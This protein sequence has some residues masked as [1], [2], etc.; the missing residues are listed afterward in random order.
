MWFLHCMVKICLVLLKI[1]NSKLPK[2]LPKWLFCFAFP[3]TMSESSFCSTSLPAL[4]IVNVVDLGHSNR[5]VAASCFSLHFPH[6]LGCGASFPMF[7]CHLCTF[8]IDTSVRV[9]GSFPPPPILETIY[10]PFMRLY[11]KSLWKN[12]S[13]LSGCSYP[14]SGLNSGICRPVF[15][16]ELVMFF[17]VVLF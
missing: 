10:F 17:V 3:P 9:F 11:F 16:R 13:P 6:D 2:R 4:R 1:K 5:C 8:L 14:F 7:I 12:L 15:S